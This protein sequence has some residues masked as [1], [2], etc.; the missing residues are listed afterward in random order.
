M[1]FVAYAFAVVLIVA[2]AYHF[3][4]PTFYYAI[5]PE[6]MPRAAANLAGG[7][8]EILIGLAILFPAT[9]TY[10]LYAAAA[11]MVLFL[12]IHVVDLLR[13]RPVIGSKAIAWGRLFL[14]FVL[15]GWLFW[16]ARRSL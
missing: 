8:A 14:Q 4:N 12:P 3:I 5:I 6:W 2:G 9:R 1:T 15:I 7:A 11:L 10:G 13:D 16:E